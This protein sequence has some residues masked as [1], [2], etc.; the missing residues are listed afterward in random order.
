MVFNA[1]GSDPRGRIDT[2]AVG[3]SVTM[4]PY[5]LVRRRYSL[6]L[7]ALRLALLD[8][9]VDAQDLDAERGFDRRLDFPASTRQVATLGWQFV[10][11]LGECRLFRND[12][13]PDVMLQ[14]NRQAAA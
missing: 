9:R 7:P 11:P 12:R 5:L 8:E 3:G 4:C 2:V 6:A 13:L 14:V 10:I 1:I